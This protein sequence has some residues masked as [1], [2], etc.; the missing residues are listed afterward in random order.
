[1]VVPPPPPTKRR[2]DRSIVEGPL[3][4]AVWRIAWP[5]M[6]QS[7]IG[8]L[9]GMVDHAM[10]GHYVGYTA[11]AAIGVSWQIFLVVVV[12]ISSLFTGMSVLVARFAGAGDH[13][14]VD[15]TVYQAFLTAVGLSLG[16]LAP[17]GYVLAPALLD[18]VNAAPEV[19]AEALPYLR[20]MF[21]FSSGMLIFF[22]LG[23][24]LRSAGDARTPLRLG[25]IVTALNITL[26]VILIRG[27]GPIPAFGTAGAAMGTVIAA[28]LVAVYALSKLWG[29]SWVVAFPRGA[30]IRPDWAIIRALF[31]FGLPTG[32]QGIAMNIGGVLLL[33]FVGSLAQSA[34]AQA[35]YAV[36]Y[37]QLFSLITWTTVG[38]MGAAA[39]V[40]GQSLGAGD[41]ERASSAVHVAARIGLLSAA[42]VGALFLLIP[43]QLLALFGMNEPA[44]VE[45]GVQLLRVLS[46]SGLFVAVALTYTGGLQGTGDTKSPLYISIVSQI[47]V[48]LGICFVIQQ[49]DTLQA[50]HIWL[51]ILAGHATRCTLSV[52]RFNQGRWRE[53]VVDIGRA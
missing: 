42:V 39:A 48:P 36:S 9:Q 7:V 19:Q 29:G 31:R 37:T 26:N 43:R 6:L 22:M 8:G 14:K 33:A 32:V 52:L 27:L 4:P 35:A 28:G 34:A 12:F 1:L 30:G 41:A 50:L 17:I 13:E 5:T 23:G 25:I 38:L 46:L 2:Y 49:T 21:V 51:A 11:N 44:A 24:A 20:I 53:I 3:L 16:V 47:A 18:V 40:A 15:R 45:L 10:V